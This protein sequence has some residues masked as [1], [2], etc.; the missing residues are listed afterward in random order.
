MPRAMISFWISV[1]SLRGFFGQAMAGGGALLLTG[2]PGV[3]KTALLKALADA[4][5]AAGTM[6]Q[7]VA[8]A[9][10]SSV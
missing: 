4:T 1:A 6:V 9:A 7:R 8:E 2:D 10:G 3:G 5:S